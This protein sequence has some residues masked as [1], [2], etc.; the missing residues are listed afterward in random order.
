VQVDSIKSK[1][2]LPGT[3]RLKLEYDI[4]LS[5]F[6]FNFYLHHYSEA[7]AERRRRRAGH[8]RSSRRW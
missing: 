4:P 1:L 7:A 2:K 3:K 8:R 6:A 5:D